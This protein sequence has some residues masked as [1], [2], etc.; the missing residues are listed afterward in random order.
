MAGG[1]GILDWITALGGLAG[2]TALAISLLQGRRRRF[3]PDARLRTLLESLIED[4]GEI[5]GFGGRP[6][7]WFLDAERRK[8][9]LALASVNG[10]IVDDSLNS[11]VGE[12]RAAY[13][14]CWSSSSPS[15]PENQ[16]R[17]QLEA[18]ERGVSA[19]GKAIDRINALLRRYGHL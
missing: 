13:L 7:P 16:A 12:A 17:L 8:R 11:S 9:E 6:S 14:D 18:A 5:T 4:F 19:A 15:Q 1:S 3:V 10:A 2:F